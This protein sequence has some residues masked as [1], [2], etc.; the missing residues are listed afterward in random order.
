MKRTIL[1]LLTAT[2]LLCTTACGSDDS[3]D[4]AVEQ[5][6]EQFEAN[7]VEGMR[8]DALF[9]AEAASAS[10]LEMQ[11]GEA[12]V[13]MAVS[14]EVKE[15][16]QEMMQANQ[17]MLN[18]LQQIAT[19]SNFVLPSTLGERHHEV[20]QEITAKTGIAFDLAYVNRLSDEHEE[21]IQRYEDIA[22]NGQDM[23][24]KQYASKQLPLLRQHQQMVEELEETIKNA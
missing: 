2:T 16:A 12:A 24:L 11:L 21:L 18:D 13:G 4:Q 9:A 5:S 15:L 1:I 23:A 19:Q 10:L 14:P 17:Q 6:M 20:Y 8:N 3:I 7:G 22:E